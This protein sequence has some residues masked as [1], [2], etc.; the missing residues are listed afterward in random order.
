[1]L[2]AVC[3]SSFV[4]HRSP[5]PVPFPMECRWATRCCASTHVTIASMTPARSMLAQKDVAAKARKG[6]ATQRSG[7]LAAPQT[8][9]ALLDAWFATRGW[10][11]WTFQEESWQSYLAGEDGLVQVP[12]GA[13]K[14]YAAVL[15]P[16]MHLTDTLL[17]AGCTCDAS[18]TPAALARATKAALLAVPGPF[19]IYI[20]PLRAVA[21]DI[22]K[23]IRAPIEAMGL[24]VLVES[25]TGDTKASVRSKQRER[26]PHVLL[27]TPESLCLLLTRENAAQLFAPLACVVV[28]EWHELLASKRGS[29]TEL[30]LARL[31][32]FSPQMRTWGLSATL[33]NSDE[34][35]AL[36]RG[37]VPTT[38][39]GRVVKADI[40]RPVR[41]ET[42]LA[43][44]P[45]DLPWAGHLGL[46]M[47]PAVLDELDLEE[48]TLVFTNTRSQAERWFHAIAYAKP[49]WAEFIALHHGSIERVDRERIEARLKDGSLRIVVATSS[50]DLGVDFSPVQKVLQIGSPKGI[51]R[52]VQRA[53][54]ANHVMGGTSIV[55]CVPTHALELL[56][57]V[58][59]RTA[60]EAGLMEA[61][62][63]YDKPLDV[64]V[65]H[66]VSCAL[67]GGFKPA[68]LLAEV[69]TAYSFRTLTDDEFAW[70]LNIAEEGGI[71]KRYP[72]FR[73]IARDEHGVYRGTTPRIAQLHRL[74]VG[75]ITGDATLE[76]CYTTGRRLGTIDEGFITGLREGAKFV[77]AG[78]VLQF[79]GVRDLTVVVKPAK[80]KTGT[81]PIWAGTRLPISESL[82]QAMREAL[83]AAAAVHTSGGVTAIGTSR[84]LSDQAPATIAPELL[85]AQ[86]LIGVQLRTSI[87]PQADELLIECATSREGHH[88]FVFPFEG[89]LVHAG[90]AALLALR[91]AKLRS[92]TFSFAVND[93]GCELLTGDK[94]VAELAQR[95]ETW[96]SLF[97]HENVLADVAA[98]VSMTQLARLAF[99]EVARVAGLVLQNY[100]GARRTGRQ[101]QASSGLIFDVLRDFDPQNLLLQQASR[102]VLDKHFESSRLSRTLARLRA[103]T[104]RIVQTQRFTPLAFP[105]VVEREASKLSSQTIAERVA[106]MRGEW[107]EG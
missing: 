25:R 46:S 10:K 68:K 98:S 105:L 58:A 81:T 76:I 79:V 30:A 54:R 50:L 49:A 92:C 74:N 96:A 3:A 14:T 4:S 59:A 27:T 28:D 70:A 34:A 24:P 22:E 83:Q 63:A 44:K 43:K 84:A 93:Y 36:L 29:A 64:L 48:P 71:L 75:T 37:A 61:R 8:A 67:G 85:A 45:E 47:L 66:M 7:Q 87:V 57:V 2:G 32:T 101:V 91:L 13:G 89:R 16:L 107:G 55:R 106:A 90:L 78:K 99:R 77:F 73:R 94:T 42:V 104:L 20:T 88:I 97:T 38:K 103:S 9:R 31:R 40:H 82:S 11:P 5:F 60:F 56:E 21:R 33:P 12:T 41:I 26:M 39:A 69:R 102:E 51:A 86:E 19:M 17:Q 53:G 80:G 15:G 35:L 95:E 1:M 23:A 18:R 6:I 52:V 100:P 65:Q 62:Y 72:E